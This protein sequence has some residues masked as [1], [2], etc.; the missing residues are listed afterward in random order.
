MKRGKRVLLKGSVLEFWLLCCSVVGQEQ[1]A[2]MPLPDQA[3]K[4]SDIAMPVMKEVQPLSAVSAEM[5]DSF[6]IRNEGGQVDYDS[7][8]HTILYTATD[9]PIYVRTGDGQEIYAQQVAADTEQRIATLFGPLTI[10]QGETLAIAEGGTYDWGNEVAHVSNVRTKTGGVI[11]RG[12]EAEY[13]RNALGRERM[14]IQHAFVTTEDIEKPSMWVGTGTLTVYPGDYGR[15]TRLSIAGEEDDVVVPVLGWIPMSHSLNPDEG[16]MPLPGVKSRWGTYLLNRYGFLL[17]NRHV[18]HGRPVADF[19]ATLLFDFRSRRGLAGGVEFSD[20]RMLRKYAN[21]RGLQIYGISDR[22]PEINPVRE[23]R[24][25]M[26]H[27]RYRVAMSELW[28]VPELSRI[29]KPKGDTAAWSVAA[30][31]NTMSDR[32]VLQDFFEDDARLNNNPDNNIRV[33][34]RTSR[35]STMLVTRFAP[36]NFYSTDERVELFHYRPRT[37]LGRSGLTYETRTSASLMRQSIPAE[38][39]ESYRKTLSRLKDPDLQ[40]YYE[41]LLNTGSYVRVNSTHEM[42]AA[43]KIMR[44][45]N[46]TPKVGGGY[47]GYYN[48]DKVGADNR[49][50]GYLGCDFDIKFHRHF[51]SVRLPGMGINGLY[52]VIH[53]YAEISHG[54]ISSSCPYVPQVDTWS[55]T[56]GNS[57]VCPMP[58]DLMEFT[59]I[60]GW[61]KWTVWRLG[62]RNTFSTVYDG[63]SRT[64]I[65]WNC[66]LDYNIDNPNTGSRFSNLYSL[67]SANITPQCTLKLET[68]TPTVRGGDGF[69]QYNTSLTVV[70]LS[71]LETQVGHRYISSHPIQGDANYA[72]FQVNVRLNE[73]YSAAARI[74]IDMVHDRTPI[75]Q[76][77]LSRKCGPWYVGTTVLI[78]D[79]G[80]KHETGVGLSFTLEET[81]TS[82][83]LDFT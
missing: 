39:R 63:E 78:R 62:M 69:N 81:N 16:Y 46:V 5:P 34:R 82:L 18:E 66:F 57:T 27:G 51:N 23:P 1:A 76:F 40:E 6:I 64:V 75:Q 7:E 77:S 58:M 17:G 28:D 53:P 83:P 70:P 73:K 42:A 29:D 80:G 32:Y 54:T 8:R 65:N 48:V 2:F 55:T 12:S 67:I 72:Y 38:Q 22:R 35:S 9:H 79:N 49:L 47:S 14:V 25:K 74:N 43:V 33:E 30:E 37:A 61:A 71:W 44:F 68:Q 20:Y 52:H 41:R 13:G 3:V 10:Y 31:L 50:M 15:I 36:N 21:T 4:A 56:L 26:R 19:L 60:D 45:L 11:I 24:K 59:G